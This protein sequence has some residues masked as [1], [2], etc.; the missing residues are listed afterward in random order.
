MSLSILII[1][2]FLGGMIVY[3]KSVEL[4]KCAGGEITLDSKYDFFGNPTKRKCLTEAKYLKLKSDLK[5]SQE[6]NLK[7]KGYDFDINDRDDLMA[8]LDYEV[9]K[10]GG[11]S[12]E[13]ATKEKIKSELLKLLE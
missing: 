13:G 3:A 12:I 1:A 2:V 6:S 5:E 7:D 11:M 10:K 4:S 9:K 8:I